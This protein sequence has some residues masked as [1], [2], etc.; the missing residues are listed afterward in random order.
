MW[1][2]SRLLG[3]CISLTC[4]GDKSILKEKKNVSF[5]PR[6]SFWD[7]IH[8]GFIQAGAGF[9]F[10]PDTPVDSWPVRG[11]QARTYLR[12]QTPTQRQMSGLRKQPAFLLV[13]SDGA[14]AAWLNAA[15]PILAAPP[16]RAFLNF[17]L[18]TSR[19]TDKWIDSGKMAEEIQPR[20]WK[21]LTFPLYPPPPR[22]Q[23]KLE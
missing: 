3:D 21:W 14:P 8:S 23:I 7:N 10:P 16:H 12:L 9:F 17:S 4:C 20:A 11:V 6:I 1:T 22:Q 19:C 15:T 5:N 2:N 18:L 13:R